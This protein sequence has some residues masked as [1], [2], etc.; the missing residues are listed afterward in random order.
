MTVPGS[1]SESVIKPIDADVLLQAVADPEGVQVDEEL[2]VVDDDIEDLVEEDCD[3]EGEGSAGGSGSV[4]GGPTVSPPGGGGPP[5]GQKIRQGMV[6]LG[7]FGNDGKR[8]LIRGIFGRPQR[9]MP[10]FL[11]PQFLQPTRTGT[12]VV[13]LLS[14]CVVVINVFAVQAEFVTI[15]VEKPGGGTVDVTVGDVR[16][17]AVASDPLAPVESDETELVEIVGETLPVVLNTPPDVVP[18]ALWVEVLSIKISATPGD[19]N[20]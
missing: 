13:E 16:L 3:C 14:D 19:A 10:P 2:V 12:T 17:S 15:S 6:K 4:T 20:C 1:V 18:G 9:I 7:S 11:S 5:L 8:Q